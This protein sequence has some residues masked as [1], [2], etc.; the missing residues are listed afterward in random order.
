MSESES[1]ASVDSLS[2]DGEFDDDLRAL[3]RSN[4]PPKLNKVIVNKQNICI[5]NIIYINQIKF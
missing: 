5:Y 3:M 4:R 2:V 1:S